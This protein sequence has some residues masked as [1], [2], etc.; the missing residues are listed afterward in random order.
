MRRI[1]ASSSYL[2]NQTRKNLAK[3]ALSM[4]ILAGLLAALLYRLFLTFQ[5]DLIEAAG[6]L[7]LLV[8]LIAFYYYLRK[9]HIYNG[10]LQGEKQVAKLLSRS[11]NNDYYLINDLYLKERGGDIDHIVLAPS[12]VFVLETKNWSG[13]ISVNG[14]EWVRAGKRDSASNPSR[15]VKNN[16]TK[17]RH[18][19]DALPNLPV[20]RVE[21]IVVLTNRHAQVRVSNSSVQVLRL[22]QLVSYIQTHGAQK[23]FTPEQLEYIGKEL[24][25]QKA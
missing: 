24:A 9:Y 12:G 11:L 1:K 15:Q 3:A 21:G 7:L 22:P 16:V 4:F 20:V 2:R 6:L 18:I 14:D 23:R 19:I 8:P 13:S 10:G 5:L 25:K 17:I